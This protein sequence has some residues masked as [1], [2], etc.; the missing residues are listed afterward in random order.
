MEN[1]SHNEHMQKDLANT[2]PLMWLIAPGDTNVGS[3]PERNVQKSLK[4]LSKLSNAHLHRARMSLHLDLVSSVLRIKRNE[5][6]GI[7]R[8]VKT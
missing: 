1:E 3:G 4:T 5:K 6:D 2:R 8:Q 7:L